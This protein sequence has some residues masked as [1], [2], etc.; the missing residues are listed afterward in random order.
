MFPSS[1]IGNIVNAVRD[2]TNLDGS[3]QLSGLAP[4]A[5]TLLAIESGWDIDLRRP[6]V[7]AR[8]LPGALTVRIADSAEKSQALREPLPVQYR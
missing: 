6:E 8:Y 1:Q 7:L 5:Y 3:F 2:Q 4:G